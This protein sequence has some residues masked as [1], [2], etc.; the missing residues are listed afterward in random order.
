M[1]TTTLR[2]DTVLKVRVAARNACQRQLADAIQSKEVVVRRI[3]QVRQDLEKTKQSLGVAS[4]C[5]QLDIGNLTAIYEYEFHLAAQLQ[6]LENECRPLEEIV[7]RRRLEVIEADREVRLIEK[8]RERREAEISQH[9]RTQEGKELE[10]IALQ[11][12]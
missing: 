5:G 6:E 8:L 3:V 4:G 7:E 11:R 12:Y 9:R 2:F 10:E 1:T